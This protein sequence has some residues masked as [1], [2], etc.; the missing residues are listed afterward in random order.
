VQ[1]HAAGNPVNGYTRYLP[2]NG[3]NA[4]LQS[5]GATGEAAAAVIETPLAV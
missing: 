1:H 3:T 5:T 2:G 4:W